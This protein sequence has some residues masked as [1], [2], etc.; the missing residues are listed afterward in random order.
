MYSGCTY[1]S[2]V[3]RVHVQQ[4]F[5]QIKRYMYVLNMIIRYTCGI[6]EEGIPSSLIDGVMCNNKTLT[7]VPIHMMHIHLYMHERITIAYVCNVCV[8]VCV[9]VCVLRLSVPRCT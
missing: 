4:V 6:G 1:E 3:T 5:I 8:C 7:L 2:C 9:C